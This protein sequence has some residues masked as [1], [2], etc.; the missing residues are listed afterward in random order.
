LLILVTGA[1]GQLGTD[2]VRSASREPHHEVVGATHADLDVGDRDAV[3]SAIT[4]LRPDVVVHTA[5]WT[6][7]DA[8]ESDPDRAWKVNSLGC[9]YIGEAARLTG[10]HVVAVSTDYVFDGLSPRP[11]TEWDRPNPLGVYGR[12]KLGGEEEMR[13]ALPGATIVRTSWVCGTN[14]SNMVKTILRLASGEGT[15]RFVD[16]QRGCPTFTEDLAGMLLRLG[17]AR[18]GGLFHVTNQGATSWFGFARAVLSAAGLDTARVEPICTQDLDPPR[19]A[20]R[21]P[22][23]VLDNTALRLAGIRLL[24]D[25]H[26]PLE[27]AVKALLTA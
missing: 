16:D 24:P 13:S 21:P 8:C 23:S 7:V 11:Y 17:V 15:L 27:R 1:G 6:A 20:P 19:P 22:N 9:R 3:M 4:S 10:A 14:G 18:R 5:A 2:V 12:S 26:E 25:Y